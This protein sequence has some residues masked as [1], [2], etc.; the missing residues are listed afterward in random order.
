[1]TRR[2]HLTLADLSGRDIGGAVQ[3]E[4]TVFRVQYIE[5][6]R[7]RT[8]IL[9]LYMDDDCAVTTDPTWPS[10]TPI[11]RLRPEQCRDLPGMPPTIREKLAALRSP[12]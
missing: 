2:K 3:V 12:K 10:T 6:Q 7:T 1:M 4:G 9:G 11:R 5:H 8:R